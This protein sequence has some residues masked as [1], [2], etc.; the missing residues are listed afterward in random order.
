MG[1]KKR[2]RNRSRNISWI[3]FIDAWQNSKDLGEFLA[4]LNLKYDSCN[5]VWAQARAARGRKKGLALRKL[6]GIGKKAGR[7]TE[8]W[9]ALARFAAGLVKPEQ[10]QITGWYPPLT[11]DDFVQAGIDARE[12]VKK[13][14]MESAQGVIDSQDE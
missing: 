11:E 10:T 6:K 7:P 2:T 13:T 4:A 3:V 8:D 1:K 12:S 5:T 9:A 14:A